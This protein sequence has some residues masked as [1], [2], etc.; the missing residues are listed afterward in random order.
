MNEHYRY[1]LTIEAFGEVV[2]VKAKIV[3]PSTETPGDPIIP[4]PRVHVVTLPPDSLTAYV[5]PPNWLERLIGRPWEYKI[6]LAERR[7]RKRAEAQVRQANRALYL[8]ERKNS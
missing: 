5:K 4:I 3:P 6:E 2:R 7:I 8:A 1:E